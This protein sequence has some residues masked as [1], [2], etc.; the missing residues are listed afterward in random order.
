MSPM[1]AEPPLPLT[2]EQRARLYDLA[3][4]LGELVELDALLPAIARHM[5]AMF[6]VQSSAVML[7]DAETDTIYAPD[8]AGA[9]RGPAV[10]RFPASRGIAGWV[11]RH[12]RVAH[13]ADARADPRWH[14]GVDGR[15]RTLLCAPLR[16]RQ[17]PVGV[18][19]LRDKAGGDFTA[20]DGSLVEAVAASIGMALDTAR[21]LAAA[22]LTVGRLRD[23]MA[24]LYGQLARG[25]A[26]DHMVGTSPAM[27]RIGQLADG[28]ASLSVPV[29]ITGERGAGKE[30]VARAIHSRGGRCER[31]FVAVHCGVLGDTLLESELFGHCRGAFSG[32]WSDKKGLFEV[33]DGGTVFLDEVGEVPL[34]TQSKL[35]RV[36]LEGQCLPVGATAP[37]AV[38]VRVVAATHRDLAA[39]VR[40]GRFSAELLCCL[41]AFPIAVPPLRHRRADI[42]LLAARLLERISR[43]VDKRVG[44]LTP[45][46]LECL[47]AYD[48]PGN[49]R[50][51]QNEMERAIA[52]VAGEGPIDAGDLSAHV[53]GAAPAP[54]ASSAPGT[55]LRHAR[56]V[57]ERQLIVEM[58]ARHGGNASRT[59][60]A[61]G[62]SRVMLHKKLRAYGLR[63]MDTIRASA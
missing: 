11:L 21:S 44:R 60:R 39:A 29:L 40:D 57:F 42:P 25:A 4:A 26:P 32:A 43:R 55:T 20:E 54:P 8:V 12:G 30:L 19:S 1:P 41:E 28:A 49:V 47:A 14:S 48:W 45:A 35:L 9:D 24:V 31:P 62:I 51:L 61:L 6:A 38:D 59:A 22:R 58:L 7:F 53:R 50:E 16:G 46:A 63:R 10:R 18:L 27:R 34:A 33:A 5:R 3:R 23:E 36:L 56:D 17:G 37:R 15:P 13:V 52:L 2:I